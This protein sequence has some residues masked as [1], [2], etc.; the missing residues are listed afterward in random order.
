MLAYMHLNQF[1]PV[2]QIIVKQERVS[3]QTKMWNI[4]Y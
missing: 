2:L 1:D 4:L 3:I